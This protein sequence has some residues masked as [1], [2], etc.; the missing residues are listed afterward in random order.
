MD[1]K[2]DINIVIGDHVRQIREKAGMTQ[3]AFA[4]KI[5]METKSVSAIERGVVGISV[6]TVKRICLALSVSSDAI[7]F[8]PTDTDREALALAERMTRLS[9]ERFALAREIMEKVL[10]GL[11]L[12]PED[13]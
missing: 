8:G 4:E 12:P 5:G 11:E 10:L 2:K 1:I 13:P 6:S 3:E 9:P 7:F